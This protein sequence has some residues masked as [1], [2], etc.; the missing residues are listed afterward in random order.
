MFHPLVSGV[1]VVSAMA[2]VAWI[3]KT[4]SGRIGFGLVGVLLG[5]TFYSYV[6]AWTW[7]FGGLGLLGLTLIFQKRWR[8]LKSLMGLVVIGLVVGSGYLV[9]S[10]KFSSLSLAG[11]FWLRTVFS[12]T[13]SYLV[14]VIRYF[15]LILLAIGV[16]RKWW[17]SLPRRFLLMLIAAAALLPDIS[18]W[19]LR[20]NVEVDHWIGRFLYPMSTFV[21]VGVFGKFRKFRKFPMFLVIVAVGLRLI[22][23]TIL[24][25]KKPVE[26]FEADQSRSELYQ[27]M[28]ENVLEE[29]VVGSLNFSEQIYLSAGTSFYPYVAR[30]DRTI[31]TS[32]ELLKRYVYL[33]QAHGF[34]VKFIDEMMVIPGGQED[35]NEG[36]RIAGADGFS[37]LFGVKHHFDPPPYLTH[38]QVVSLAHELLDGEVEQVGR[39]DYLLVSNGSFRNF[40]NFQEC[41]LVFENEVYRLYQW[42]EC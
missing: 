28:N 37:M 10:F 11:D 19:I 17:T 1:V 2:G 32:D 40:Q 18:Q 16:S 23:V 4:R 13:Q 9:N 20:V 29:S 36:L 41:Q 8:E 33:V 38:Q 24:E 42:D 22:S 34:G 15:L 5:L 7:V 14:V 35:D 6:F 12:Q 25:V 31:A 21:L 26:W 30:G 3:L 27:W 39:L